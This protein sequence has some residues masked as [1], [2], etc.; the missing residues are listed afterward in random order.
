MP[1]AI[2]HD[3]AIL[4]KIGS[5]IDEVDSAKKTASEDGG[6]SGGYKKDPGSKGGMST[7]PTADADGG[8]HPASVGARGKENE[9][10]IK[11]K[12][13]NSANSTS[14]SVGAE[15]KGYGHVNIGMN[16]SATGEDKSVENGY[17]G[18]KQDP[19]TTTPVDAS[20]MGEKYSSLD[21]V[22]LHKLACDKMD[23]F[24]TRLG[25]DERLTSK[26]AAATPPAATP[27]KKGEKNASD[28]AAAGY[29]LAELA[30]AQPNDPRLVKAA[31]GQELVAS[32]IRQAY[33][34][35]DMVGEFLCKLAKAETDR[36][37]S[38]GD[39]SMMPPGMPPG[40]PNAML[41]PEMGGGGAGA[42]APGAGG[43]MGGAG[44]PPPEGGAGGMEGGDPAAAEGA[45]AGGPPGDEEIIELANGLIE[46]GI[47]PEKLI[48]ALEQA[49]GQ[50]GFGEPTAGA[51][52]EPGAGAGD[53]GGA[54]KAA[55]A[56]ITRP[57][58]EQLYKVAHLVQNNM[59]SGKFR[60]TYH[61]ANSKKAND[62]KEFVDY[63]GYVRE[64]L[65]F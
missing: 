39:P 53:E 41:P 31:A 64:V 26:T 56:P 45:G 14:D 5:L 29:A 65:K 17:K 30:N 8:N 16:Q 47:P 21:T 50:P 12:I 18:T 10:D 4:S 36:M 37:K 62:R 54:Q 40:D 25:A 7:H 9:S 44:A 51:G 6:G 15:G 52:G 49:A 59:T 22:A 28:A 27:P 48:A 2:F 33:A 43:E 46:A 32:V 11:E 34:D 1:N 3:D 24:M 38:A 57:E 20:S 42:M 58:A 19:G 13:P 61:Q 60:R 23:A 35:A 55:A 63:L